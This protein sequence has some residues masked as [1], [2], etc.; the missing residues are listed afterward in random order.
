VIRRNAAIKI[1]SS[2]VFAHCRDCNRRNV[3]QPHTRRPTRCE[4]CSFLNELS[5]CRD[6]VAG[7]RN[8]PRGPDTAAK[9]DLPGFGFA[10]CKCIYVRFSSLRS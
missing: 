3:L 6:N 2:G 7:L 8:R 5:R 4:L 1:Q 9:I 10:S